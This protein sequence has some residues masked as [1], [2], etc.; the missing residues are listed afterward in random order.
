VRGLVA[1]TIACSR[2]CEQVFYGS[3]HAVDAIRPLA[4]GL[5]LYPAAV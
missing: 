3:L 4:H 2:E 5:R 1:L